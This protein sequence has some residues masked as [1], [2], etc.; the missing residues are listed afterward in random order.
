MTLAVP[1]IPGLPAGLRDGF[2]GSYQRKQDEAIHLLLI[3]ARRRLVRIET[4]FRIIGDV[5]YLAADLGSKV[6]SHGLR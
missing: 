2:I 4:A 5:R 3:L 1:G 6:G